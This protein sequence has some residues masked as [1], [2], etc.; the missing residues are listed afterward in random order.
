MVIG[1]LVGEETPL[2]AYSAP[3]QEHTVWGERVNPLPGVGG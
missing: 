3:E 1:K 2:V